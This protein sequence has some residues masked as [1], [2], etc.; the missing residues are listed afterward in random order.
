MIKNVIENKK[1]SVSLHTGSK[2]KAN[3]GFP[4]I[5]NIL[6]VQNACCAC[7][8]CSKVFCLLFSFIPKTEIIVFQHTPK[9]L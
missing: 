7:V 4:M 5:E 6:L 3:S 9:L 2:C 8:A 1:I